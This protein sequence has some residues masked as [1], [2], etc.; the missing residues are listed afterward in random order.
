MYVLA[1]IKFGWIRFDSKNKNKST[2]SWTLVPFTL[3]LSAWQGGPGL[4]QEP[5][6]LRLLLIWQLYSPPWRLPLCDSWG[7]LGSSH[8]VHI[9]SKKEAR[10]R[11]GALCLKDSLKN[12]SHASE[13]YLRTSYHLSLL[14]YTTHHQDVGKTTW[15]VSFSVSWN[16]CPK[17]NDGVLICIV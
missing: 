13:R 8:H 14:S 12:T 7:C 11:K 4:E 9:P 5:R 10:A 6:E 3:T 15:S 16:L 2:L 17:F 1:R